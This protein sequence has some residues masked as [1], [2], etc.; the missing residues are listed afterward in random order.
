MSGDDL[1]NNLVEA[2]SQSYLDRI[3]GIYEKLDATS[4]DKEG[5]DVS[6]YIRKSLVIGELVDKE[7]IST[8]FQRVTDVLNMSDE[9]LIAK[10]NKTL[11]DELGVPD[12]AHFTEDDLV[13]PDE[14]ALMMSEAGHNLAKLRPE[15]V[16]ETISEA[17]KEIARNFAQRLGLEN[18]DD[19][20]I[21]GLATLNA[22]V[23]SIENDSD[24][25]VNKMKD[26]AREAIDGFTE[27]TEIKQN[28][29][30]VPKVIP[31]S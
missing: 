22:V 28:D 4:P 3:G 15:H 6:R 30:V 7:N 19:D 26:A 1:T 13:L 2:K 9:E 31:S 16:P 14:W 24:N 25:A 27:M 10:A 11:T 17:H 20:V 21:N 29:T 8:E 5:I 23:E 12:P 18:P